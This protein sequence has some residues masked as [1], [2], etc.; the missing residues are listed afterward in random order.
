MMGWCIFK[1]WHPS[2][3][4]IRL[5][6]GQVSFWRIWL[7]V[8]GRL[9]ETGVRAGYTPPSLTHPTCPEKSY[10]FSPFLTHTVH[11]KAAGL[12]QRSLSV[13]VPGP[14]WQVRRQSWFGSNAVLSWPIWGLCT[15]SC[16][17]V[18]GSHLKSKWPSRAQ[19]GHRERNNPRVI[20]QCSSNLMTFSHVCRSAGFGWQRPSEH[21]RV[22]QEAHLKVFVSDWTYTCSEQLTLELGRCQGP[23]APFHT[24]RVSRH[25]QVILIPSHRSYSASWDPMQLLKTK[26]RQRSWHRNTTPLANCFCLFTSSPNKQHTSLSPPTLPIGQI[27][28]EP[29]FSERKWVW[30]LIELTVS[31]QGRWEGAECV[32]QFQVRESKGYKS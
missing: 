19:P 1:P 29:F 14:G 4:M 30:S 25:R 32:L 18:E 31:E 17:G 11:F 21:S 6:V 2:C 5:F 27:H 8:P 10:R 20:R 23:L 7:L 3:L 15:C 26:I 28:K 13:D 16:V 12:P 24:C 22:R 9:G